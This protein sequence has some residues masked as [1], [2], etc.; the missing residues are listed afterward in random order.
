MVA[1]SVPMIICAD[2]RWQRTPL[3]YAINQAEGRLS[4]REIG[5]LR[6]SF[7]EGA[8]EAPGKTPSEIK[9][10]S[11]VPRAKTI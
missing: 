1:G 7:V 6:V 8:M 4:K 5:A 2:L 10:S 11:Q 3:P 9:K